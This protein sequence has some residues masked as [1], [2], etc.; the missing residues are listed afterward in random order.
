MVRMR[1][2]PWLVQLRTYLTGAW[3]YR[4]TAM[5][6]AWAICV[7]GW[8]AIAFIPNQFQAV[9]K[10]YVDTDT[11]MAPLLKGLTVSTDPEQQVSVML[12]TLLTRPNLEQVVH[13]THPDADKLSSAQ[14]ANEVQHLLDHIT[15]TPL[16]TQK[17]LRISF[18]DNDPNKSLS[19][20][21]TLLSIFVDSN[22]GD[23]RRDLEGAQTFLDTK[24]AEYEI[25]L[26]QA[27]QRR[28][29]FRQDNMD[30][31]PTRSRQN[32]PQPSCK[33]PASLLAPPRPGSAVCDAQL[34]AIP[35][36]DLYR[37]TRPDRRWLGQRQFRQHW[38]AAEACCS[39]CAEAKQTLLELQSRYHRRPS[40]R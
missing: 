30:V 31:L 18:S 27:E 20:A 10:I 7:V 2:Q 24:I 25:L 22:I 14:M 1:M 37:W 33:P 13:L 29:D 38:Q 40:R 39:A 35:K 36:V 11:M 5:A 21:Q 19:V 23:K 8:V 3:H 15:I 26:K 16:G 12:N 4:W 6:I 28:A 9:A 34:A 32:R 17:P